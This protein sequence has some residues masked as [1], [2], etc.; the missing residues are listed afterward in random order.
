MHVPQTHDRTQAPY[1]GELRHRV[2]NGL[3]RTIVVVFYGEYKDADFSLSS[4][5][6]EQSPVRGHS[7]LHPVDGYGRWNV[8]DA[9]CSRL[10]VPTN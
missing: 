4:K 7:L 1:I 10:R 9:L 6:V 8:A 5:A 3:V 2:F